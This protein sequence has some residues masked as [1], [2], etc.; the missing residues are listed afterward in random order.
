MTITPISSTIRFESNSTL[1]NISNLKLDNLRDELPLSFVRQSLLTL[2]LYLLCALIAFTLLIILFGII[3][4]TYRKHCFSSPIIDP[5]YR[6]SKTKLNNR[7][8]IQIENIDNDNQ[9]IKTID[10]TVQSC[11]E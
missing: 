4:F 8:D 10:N 5:R 1:S 9:N 2:I 6:L 3:V 7:I 11:F